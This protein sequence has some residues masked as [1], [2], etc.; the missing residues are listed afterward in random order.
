MKRRHKQMARALL[1][2]YLRA[3]ERGSHYRCECGYGC[4]PHAGCRYA[5]LEPMSAATWHWLR[6]AA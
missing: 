3:W 2:S 5:D 4:P 6:E 1:R